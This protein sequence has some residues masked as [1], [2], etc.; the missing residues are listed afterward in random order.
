VCR[1]L[2][3]EEVVGCHRL[4]RGC[5]WR[6]V[7]PG[8][9]VHGKR[10]GR[11]YA[12]PTICQRFGERR[13]WC[14]GRCSPAIWGVVSLR[15]VELARLVDVADECAMCLGHQSSVD[16]RRV[17]SELLRYAYAQSVNSPTDW[18]YGKD[19]SGY[20]RVGSGL[21]ALSIPDPFV[22]TPTAQF[23]VYSAGHHVDV[24]A[25]SWSLRLRGEVDAEVSVGLEQL[26]SLPQHEVTS[27]LE[28]AGNGRRLFIEAAGY[29]IP[30]RNMQTPWMLGGLG[31]AHWSGPRLRDV[32]DL[33]GVSTAAKWIAPCGLDDDTAEPE[34]PRM[35]L[36]ID[37]A[38]DDDTIIA[39]VMNGEPLPTAHGAPARLLVPGWIGAYSMKWIDEIQ[40]SNEWVS[41]WRSDEFYVLRDAAGTMI[42]PA[43]T[44]PVKSNLAMNYP[45][46][47]DAGAQLLAGV[48]RSG[49]APITNVVWRIDGGEWRPAELGE[50]AARWAWTPFTID[51]DL[52]SGEHIIETRATDGAG[53][54]QPAIQP[55][56]PN[57]VLWHAITPH[58]IT[59]N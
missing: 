56:H 52:T 27:W 11:D 59:A 47:L 1:V 10:R 14:F 39:L 55:P 15:R 17:I 9:V 35:C 57:G 31:L 7:W 8:R 21:E 45:A 50:V 22:T 37:K 20:R 42:G 23:F 16:H 41:S 26:R 40:V 19:V 30:D 18:R 4:W 6:C 49:E 43:T 2:V 53:N 13:E 3:P 36:P 34:P 58:P 29:D 38:L 24:D 28:C 33:A 12:N 5:G 44:H 54:V 46:T 32:L 51:V 25:P 48:A